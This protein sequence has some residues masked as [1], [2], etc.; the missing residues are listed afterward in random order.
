MRRFFALSA[1]IV[2]NI[3]L[4]VCLTVGTPSDI[5]VCKAK[6]WLSHFTSLLGFRETKLKEFVRGLQESTTMLRT[7]PTHPVFSD[8]DETMATV[9]TANQL[10]ESIT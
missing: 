6:S 10:D 5:T 4:R 8:G 9:A 7:G 2:L 3:R 1:T